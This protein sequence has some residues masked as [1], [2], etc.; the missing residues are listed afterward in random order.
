M[1]AFIVGIITVVL[2]TQLFFV[3]WGGNQVK[4]LQNHYK[5]ALDA[6]T[7]AAAKHISYSTQE[8]LEGL[9]LGFGVGLEHSNNIQIDKD[10]ALSW[11][12][13]V[14]FA[15]LGYTNNETK[16]TQ[17]KQKIPFKAIVTFDRIYIANAS[18]TWVYEKEYTIPYNGATYQFT[19][20]EQ[21]KR[22]GT[23]KKDSDWGI[24]PATRVK[25]VNQFIN[26]TINTHINEFAT[27]PREIY[28]V[29]LGTD[30][31]D[32]KFSLIEGANFIVFIEGFPLPSF[33]TEG[34]SNSH[35]AFS[36]GGA[37]IRRKK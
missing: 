3:Q 32:H 20:S 26:T 34:I 24:P 19:L 16:K 12:Y 18:D 14:F 22:G 37:E 15:N 33:D 17:L 2:A 27:N 9:S 11:F 13:E 30:I 5:K 1:Q 25:L 31:S 8:Q 4:Q 6:G 35:Y 36:M 7:D 10:K 23:W 21:V 29:Q 28:H